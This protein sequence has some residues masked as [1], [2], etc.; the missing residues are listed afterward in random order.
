MSV[1]WTEFSTQRRRDGETI[2]DNN[3]DNIFFDTQK[4]FPKSAKKL[5]SLSDTIER[6]N[7]ANRSGVR[8]VSITFM[9]KKIVPDLNCSFAHRIIHKNLNKLL[10]NIKAHCYNISIN[11]L[12]MMMTLILI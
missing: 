1:S 9:K 8:R 10:M 3:T 12:I 7:F 5:S 4:W 6:S 11:I 2:V